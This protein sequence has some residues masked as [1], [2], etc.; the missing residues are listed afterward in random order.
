MSTPGAQGAT[1]MTGA[2]GATG[3]AGINGYRLSGTDMA[4]WAGQRVQIVGTVIPTTPGASTGAAGSTPMPEF[5]VQSVQP[6]AGPC[7]Q[8]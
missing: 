6:V 8:R 3:G 7:P 4:S 1:P 2:T 5:R